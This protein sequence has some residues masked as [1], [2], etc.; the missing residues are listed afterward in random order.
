MHLLINRLS[1]S[2]QYVK[3]FKMLEITYLDISGSMGLIAS[4]LL[5]FNIIIGIFLSTGFKKTIYWKKLPKIIQ[6]YSLIQIHNIT[7][8]CSFVF[9]VLHLIFLMLY[10]EGK[11][12]IEHIFN[13][14][15]A[16]TQANIVLLGVIGFY[17]LILSIITSQKV[18]KKKLGFR[19]WKNIHFLAYL[20]GLAFLIHGVM[21]DPQLKDRPIDWFDAE[22]FFS[23]ACLIAVV[24]SI[25][26]RVKYQ[27][28]KSKQK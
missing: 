17:G 25:I 26:L 20:S 27:F 8:Y 1:S 16:P 12:T 15:D 9:V 14:L 7:A 11:F 23:E 28:N 4:G 2:F 22:K 21:I 10:K 24:V 13:P 19:L 18:L 6:Q 3:L 5:T